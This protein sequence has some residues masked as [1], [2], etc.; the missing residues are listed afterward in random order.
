VGN[1]IAVTELIQYVEKF[2]GLTFKGNGSK[3]IMLTIEPGAVNGTTDPELNKQ[4]YLLKISPEE[5]RVTGNSQ[6]G[7]F[8]GVQSLLQLFKKAGPGQLLLPEGE[9]RDWP[10]LR[11]RIIHWDTKNHLDRISSKRIY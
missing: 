2:H 3:K 7:L 10:N 8:Y 11:L 5:V 1:D 9:I 6:A 4:G